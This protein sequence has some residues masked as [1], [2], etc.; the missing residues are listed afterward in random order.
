M[1]AADRMRQRIMRSPLRG[2]EIGIERLSLVN[3]LL[4]APGTARR[5]LDATEQ[6][7][8]H[9]VGHLAGLQ[10]RPTADERDVSEAKL[11]SALLEHSRRRKGTCRKV[12]DV[13]PR[14]IH[15]GKRNV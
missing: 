14:K 9:A 6:I 5:E 15:R 11:C 1:N 12:S 8:S 4:N 13:R 3:L 10:K 2:G 7:R